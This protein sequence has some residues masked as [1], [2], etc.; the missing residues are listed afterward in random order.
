MNHFRISEAVPSQNTTDREHWTDTRKRR[1]RYD[2]QI[3]LAIVLKYRK[4]ERNG[5]LS[6]PKDMLVTIHSQ[7]KRLILDDANLRGG[8][9]GLVDAIASIGL[10]YDDADEFCTIEYTQVAGKEYK[11]YFTEITIEKR[12]VS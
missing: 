1:K 3:A 4:K 5:M 10:I 12:G 9:K 6:S 7:R 11:E 8:A 2:T